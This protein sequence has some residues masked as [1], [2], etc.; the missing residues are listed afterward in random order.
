M[1]ISV[2]NGPPSNGAA[3]GQARDDV[4]RDDMSASR[5]RESVADGKDK[6]PSI[7]RKSSNLDIQQCAREGRQLLSPSPSPRNLSPS[8]V[9]S[10]S[11]RT[12][13]KTSSQSFTLNGLSSE[14]SELLSPVVE[15]RESSPDGKEGPVLPTP[16]RGLQDVPER[17]KKRR[18]SS[19]L[20]GDNEKILKL[21]AAEM[22]ELTS[23]P[24]SLPVSP[25]KLPT[26]SPFMIDA[27]T[28]HDRK[29]SSSDVSHLG[30]DEN[31]NSGFR[32]NNS[33][34]P[35]QELTDANG[36]RR[37]GPENYNKRPSSSRSM[38]TQPPYSQRM[39][40]YSKQTTPGP[41]SPKRRPTNPVH[42][43][44]SIDLNLSSNPQFQNGNSKPPIA[45]DP[46]SPMPPSI[47]IPPMSIPTYLQLELSS[48]R[49]SPLYIYRSS[50]S[51]FPYESSKIKFERLLNFLLLPPQLES[52]LYFGSLAC[53]DAWLYTFTILPLRF[54]KA[55][56]ILITWWFEAI[57]KEV[58]FVLGFIWHGA[59]RM[60]HRRNE[61][62]DSSVPPS[63]SASRARRPSIST[64]TSYQTSAARPSEI[65]NRIGS[66]DYFKVD[67]ERRPRQGWGR[68]HR[69]SKSQ[70]S[71]L[72]SYNKADLL[73]G[74][75]IVVSCVILMKL[76][77]SRMY[78]SIRAQSAIK[79]YVI[80]NGLEVGC[81]TYG[82]GLLL[83]FFLGI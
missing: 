9:I 25:M 38:T 51:E 35:L 54:F 73:Q 67:S 40:S 49:P 71:S 43:P 50:S 17:L 19:L 64:T 13:R 41:T 22:E 30:I 81:V 26:S 72:S 63:R 32:K 70:P 37:Q 42:R 79:L 7:E 31:Q 27:V 24:E 47:P 55:A 15:E 56:A 82:F 76:D 44:E 58:R 21:T 78:H 12:E 33:H 60:W 66:T 80:Y 77:A 39:A 16:P 74:A 65:L 52:V 83:T 45:I 18:K 3:N 2:E 53:L 20:K 69:R 11:S 68:R 14:K 23:A 61:P 48:G 75:V 57:A 6:A 46:P 34:E 36:D 8:L 1:A 28:N 10:D 62:R 5:D 59:G 29:R 4:G